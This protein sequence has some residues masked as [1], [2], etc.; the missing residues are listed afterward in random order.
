MERKEVRRM[1]DF[2][3]R[4][5]VLIPIVDSI[6]ILYNIIS[7]GECYIIV[8]TKWGKKIVIPYKTDKSNF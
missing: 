6:I 4:R 7:L 1:E 8:Y 2:P 3:V 5:N